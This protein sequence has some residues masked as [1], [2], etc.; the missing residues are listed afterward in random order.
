[1]INVAEW[2]GVIIALLVILV[3]IGTGAMIFAT[4]ATFNY[5]GPS[6]IQILVGGVVSVVVLMSLGVAVDRLDSIAKSSKRS[7][8]A[9]ERRLG[10]KD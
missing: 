5:A 1:M 3:I 4:A 9:L 6:W 7:A 10:R 8:D 2:L